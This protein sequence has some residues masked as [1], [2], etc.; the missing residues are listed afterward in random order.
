MPVPDIGMFEGSLVGVRKETFCGGAFFEYVLELP[1]LPVE[2]EAEL[3]GIIEIESFGASSFREEVRMVPG[4][5]DRAV[6][7]LG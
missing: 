3:E 4:T 6:L 7:A 1:G 5:A 2:R